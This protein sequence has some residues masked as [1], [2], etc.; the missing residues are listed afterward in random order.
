MP[1]F[2]H[3]RNLKVFPWLLAAAVLLRS[4]IAPGYMLAASAGTG[5]AIIFCDGP[6]SINSKNDEHAAHHHYSDDGD[7]VRSEIHVSPVCSDWSTSGLLVFNAIFEPVLF[8]AKPAETGP[9][10]DTPPFP[11]RPDNTRTIRGPPALV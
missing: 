1:F 7:Q 2:R 5:F 10:Y 9:D 6:V 4:F 3:K 11:Q 8:D